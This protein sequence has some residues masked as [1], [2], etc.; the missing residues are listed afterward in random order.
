MDVIEVRD[1][2]VGVKKED[3]PSLASPHSTSKITTCDDLSTLKTYGFRGEALSSMARMASLSVTSRTAGDD[4]AMTYHFS[5]SGEVTSSH[6]THLERGVSV[7][8]SNLFKH[9]PVRRQCYKKAKRCKEELKKV[10][11]YLLA[12]GISH[13]E[14]RFLLRHN[15][16]TLWQKLRA[17]DF[18]LNVTTILG[19]DSFK[20]MST[21]NYQCFDPMVKI[22]AFVPQSHGD[23]N[24]LTRSTPDRIFLFINKRPV[25][26]K[27]LIQVRINYR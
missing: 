18:Q 22:R 21:L 15:K 19:V 1:N 9:M 7:M 16:H 5:S 14:V 6:P 17:P 20:L 26:I 23:V 8:V 3:I 27:P 12:F 13:P 24:G 11:D 4:I 2:G 25:V 10:E